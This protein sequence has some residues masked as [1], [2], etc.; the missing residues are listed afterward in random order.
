MLWGRVNRVPC[1]TVSSSAYLSSR[2][3]NQLGE[4]N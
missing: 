1:G 4:T 3:A 2:W